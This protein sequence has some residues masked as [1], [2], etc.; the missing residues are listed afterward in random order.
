MLLLHLLIDNVTYCNLLSLSFHLNF[1]KIENY[2]ITT[3][4]GT[5]QQNEA[6]R[7]GVRNSHE[8]IYF[9]LTGSYLF[10]GPSDQTVGQSFEFGGIQKFSRLAE[11]AGNS[12]NKHTVNCIFMQKSRHNYTL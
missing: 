12:N 1:I 10:R 7:I 6:A 11:Q 3:I 5:V 8:G 4:R 9:F 2:Y